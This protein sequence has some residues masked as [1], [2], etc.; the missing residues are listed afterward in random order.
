MPRERMLRRQRKE[1]LCLRISQ[2]LD[3]TGQNILCVFGN[4]IW[5]AVSAE[6][7]NLNKLNWGGARVTM[8]AHSAEFPRQPEQ[9]QIQMGVSETHV[10][11]SAYSSKQILKEK[12]IATQIPV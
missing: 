3:T 4:C 12:K 10:R 11:P 9:W 1:S 8:N 2:Y 7:L 5:G 6:K